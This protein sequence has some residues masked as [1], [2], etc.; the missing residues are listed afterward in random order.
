MFSVK[1]EGL[2]QRDFGSRFSSGLGMKDG[3][4]RYGST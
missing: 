2:G 1:S 3:N 4:V